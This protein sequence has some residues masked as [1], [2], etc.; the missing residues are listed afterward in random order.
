MRLMKSRKRKLLS[1]AH[2]LDTTGQAEANLCKK[3]CVS[4]EIHY[5]QRPNKFINHSLILGK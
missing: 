2:L 1:L 5:N 3:T 4:G